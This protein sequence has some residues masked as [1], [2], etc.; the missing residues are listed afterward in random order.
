M[1]IQEERQ[2]G[3]RGDEAQLRYVPTNFRPH[4]FRWSR[5]RC[6]LMYPLAGSV[7]L[8]PV[9][10]VPHGQDTVCLHTVAADNLAPSPIRLRREQHGVSSRAD[11][12]PGDIEHG[13]EAQAQ[14]V[15]D[16]V[17]AGR[18]RLCLRTREPGKV[19]ARAVD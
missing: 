18:T 8:P 11:M 12:A 14:G 13:R 4:N 1:V 5:E 19:A 3:K 6:P 9:P 17:Y 10:G 15:A 7:P 16:E 2:G